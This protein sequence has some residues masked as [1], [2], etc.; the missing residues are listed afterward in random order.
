MQQ[1]IQE[2][3]ELFAAHSSAPIHSVE[4]IPQSGSDRVYFR[5]V[6][7]EGTMIATYSKN[8]KE[9]NTFINF[10]RHFKSKDCPVPIIYGVNEA[11]TI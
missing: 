7:A 5:I 9:N 1:V 8:I 11:G 6:H 3:K 4:K 2:I 10:S